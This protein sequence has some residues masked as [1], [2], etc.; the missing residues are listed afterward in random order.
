M[1]CAGR[2]ADVPLIIAVFPVLIIEALVFWAVASWL[3]LGW[4]LFLMFALMAVGLLSAPLEM[5]RVGALATRQKVSVGRVAGDYGLLTAGAFL[6]GSPGIASSVVGL[7]LILPPTRAVVRGILAKKL[8][9]SIEDLGVRSFQATRA[10]RPGTSYGSFT[11]PF[12]PQP[13]PSDGPAEVIDE[14]EIEQWTKDIRPE[15]FR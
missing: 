7:F 6:A 2:V 11:D 1:N 9:R 13:D 8:M 14:S 15:D 5:R 12:A 3:G 4:A 10:G